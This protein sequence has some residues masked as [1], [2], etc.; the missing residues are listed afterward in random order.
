MEAIERI[1]RMEEVLNRAQNVCGEL[2]R[3]LEAFEALRE[4]LP[5]LEAYYGSRDWFNDLALDEAG[6]LPADLRRGV[7]SEDGIYNL[8]DRRKELLEALHAAE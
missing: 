8:L 3:A 1:T 6:L 7:L 4:E 2:E 5:A